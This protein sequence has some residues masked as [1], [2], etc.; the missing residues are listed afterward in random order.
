MFYFQDKILINSNNI[1]TMEMESNH[2]NLLIMVT[3]SRERENRPVEAK[4]EEDG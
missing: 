2:S 4:G 3:K 1:C